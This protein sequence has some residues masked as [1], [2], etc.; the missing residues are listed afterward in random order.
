MTP[1][2]TVFGI[3]ELRRYILGFYLEKKVPIRK[4]KTCKDKTGEICMMPCQC[5]CVIYC[6]CWIAYKTSCFRRPQFTHDI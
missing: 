3:P 1:E 4:Q 5:C 2:E 6:C